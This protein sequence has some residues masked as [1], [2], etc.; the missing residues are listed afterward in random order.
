MQGLTLLVQS[1]MVVPLLTMA[2]SLLLTKAQKHTPAWMALP[3][4]SQTGSRWPERGVFVAGFVSSSALMVVIAVCFHFGVLASKIG[5]GSGNTLHQ[6]GSVS[7]TISAICNGIA[8][9]L[10][11]VCAVGL[12]GTA[13]APFSYGV[14][15][16]HM[17][18]SGKH[19]TS[20][21]LH[22]GFAG[23]FF[24]AALLYLFT[25]VGLFQ[26]TPCLHPHLHGTC[27]AAKVLLLVVYTASLRL[28]GIETH[29]SEDCAKPYLLSAVGQWVSVSAYILFIGSYSFDVE[30]LLAK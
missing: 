10:L 9:V 15:D 8:G 22:I 17:S 13:L 11:L 6:A 21:K 28:F 2:I 19:D 5:N 14:F 4:I 29:C 16:A 23:T 30:A 25:V 1:A 12:C 20:S 3:Q 27:F 18:P 26:W 7:T 24:I